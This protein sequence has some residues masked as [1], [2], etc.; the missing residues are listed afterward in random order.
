MVPGVVL[1]DEAI[2]LILDG[3]PGMAVAG[4]AAGKF[5]AVVLP[6]QAVEVACGAV[7]GDRLDFVCAVG[8]AVVARG[9]LRL[10]PAAATP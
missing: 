1:L 3:L 10:V 5:V 7:A 6:G 8:G 4:I 2:A 9:S